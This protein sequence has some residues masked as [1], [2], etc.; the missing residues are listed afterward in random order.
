MYEPPAVRNV[1]L[2][3]PNRRGRTPTELQEAAKR[4]LWHAKLLIVCTGLGFVVPWAI[5]SEG[6]PTYVASTRL[7][8][9]ATTDGTASVA[10]TVAA[11][12][13]SPSQ[14]A[15]AL[16]GLGIDE[17]PDAFVQVVS[18]RA[19]GDSGIVELSVTDED[20]V[21][22]ASL[23]NALRAEVAQVM[24]ETRQAVYPLP[25]TL[26]SASSSAA[27]AIPPL[28]IQDLV[29]GALF[30]LILGIAAASLIEALNPT[31]VG[32]DAIAAQLGAPVLGVLPLAPKDDSRDL[33]WVRWR[34]GA[35]AAMSGV[36][37]VQ[38]TAAGPRV[39]LFPISAALVT[40]GAIPS[41]R[42][43]T[44]TDGERA[45]HL[46]IGI[47]DPFSIYPERSAGLVVVTPRAIKRTDIESAKDLL[48]ITGWPAV[49]AIVYTG[50]RGT[51][52][53]GSLASV[54]GAVGRKVFTP[55]RALAVGSYRVVTPSRRRVRQVSEA[56]QDRAWRPP[57]WT[58]RR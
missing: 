31:L 26:D 21:L 48:R 19:L 39:D 6:Q 12:A 3:W 7:L 24:R 14:L 40:N 23:A 43:T 35:Q 16:L 44:G 49:G 54:A 52:V 29:L 13:T 46:D 34:L 56:G 32:K 42:F 1:G 8:V 38:L 28:R 50:R 11:I 36:A 5:L 55:I 18:V 27:E 58:P 2:P 4:I 37:T 45:S 10:D 57:P 47:L 53:F 30:G 33:P 17:E 9:S 25:R 51:W 20:P 15:S 41:R 22:A